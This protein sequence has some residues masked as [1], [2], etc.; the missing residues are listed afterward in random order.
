MR[1]INPATREL[2]YKGM[3][4]SMEVGGV[5]VQ[6]SHRRTVPSDD[7]DASSLPSGEKATPRTG[8]LWP[9]SVRSVVHD[10]LSHSRTV[11]SS[12]ADASS[13]PSGKKGKKA[14]PDDR[15]PMALER[16]QYFS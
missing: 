5:E 10:R 6:M 1:I 12:D 11:P 8:F 4:L 16:P 15:I 13:L 2:Q 9:S 7:A 3:M 14:I